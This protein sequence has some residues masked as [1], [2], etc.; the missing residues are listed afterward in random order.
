LLQVNVDLEKAKA[1]YDRAGKLIQDKIIT[2]NDFLSAKNEY[3][4]L[5]N[6]YNNLNANT[7]SGGNLVRSTV[8]GYIRELF[9]TEGQKVTP[10]QQLASIVT[11]HNL[12][13][14]ADVSPDHVNVLP[15]ITSAN[16]TVG[17]SDKLY[18]LRDMN[19]KKISQ[20]KSTGS[21]SYYIPLY[22]RLDYQPELIDGTFAEVYLTGNEIP[23][24]I[25]V[26]NSA[27]L[28]EFGK[29]YVFVKDEDG[30][31]LKRYVEPGYGDGENTLI[32]SGLSEGETIVATGTYNV[33]IAQSST[34]APAHSHNH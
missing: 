33:K 5:L 21:S 16:F 32:L 6:T 29:I 19:G 20:G 12:V 2:Q 23:D 24:A 13:L 1:N 18:R 8:N 10:G 25:V 34:A 11:E 28:E 4:K 22:F 9:V 31:F 7:G 26:P 27:L 14:Q 15:T 30:D 17:Y 3:D